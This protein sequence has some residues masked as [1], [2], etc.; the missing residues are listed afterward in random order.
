MGAGTSSNSRSRQNGRRTSQS[1]SRDGS[2]NRTHMYDAAEK[3]IRVK[4]QMSDPQV[5]RIL[6]EID[7]ETLIARVAKKMGRGI[8]KRTAG[9]S[10][11]TGRTGRT[12]RASASR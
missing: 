3:G 6:I 7:W 11:R 10:G 1:Q 5:A 12:R 8:K 9:R 2:D 4:A